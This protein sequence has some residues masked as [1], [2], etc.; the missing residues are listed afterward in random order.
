MGLFGKAPEKPPKEMVREWTSKLRREGYA[1]ERQI[2][3]IQREQEKV[4]R[5]LKDA[6]KKGQKDVATVLAKEIIHSRKA[7][8]KI[9]AAKA[10]LQSVTYQMKNQ[11]AMVRM[12]N[13]FEKSTEVMK[14]MQ[15]L[16]KLPEI[17]ANMM[18]MSKEMMKAGIIEEMMDDAFESVNDDEDLEEEAEEE[19]D[20][21]LFELTAGELGRAPAVAADSLPAGAVGGHEEEEEEEEDVSDMQA[22]L[23]ALRS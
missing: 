8:S 18:E 22:R 14:S 9:Y 21:V 13:S 4:K 23:Q 1:L 5:S 2:K 6:A 11:E 19:V 15:Q 7:I 12:S 10:Q 3:G 17:Q 16:I 20:K